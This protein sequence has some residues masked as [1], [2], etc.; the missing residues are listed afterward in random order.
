MKILKTRKKMVVSG[1]ALTVALFAGG[2]AFAYF[3]AG[4]AGSGSAP[5]G[6]ASA[7]NITQD[8]SGSAAY[9]SLVSPTPPDTWSQSYGGTGIT[10]FGDAITLAGGT[11]PLNSV[12]VAL[13]SQACGNGEGGTDLCDDPRGNVPASMTLNVYGRKSRRYSDRYGYFKHSRFPYR[14]PPAS[15]GAGRNLNGPGYQNDGSQWYD[16]NHGSATHGTSY[17]RG[18]NFASQNVTLRKL[19]LM[20]LP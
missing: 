6:T 16:S 12:V 13:D 4:G 11:A 18:I 19:M 15:C 7:V 2:A 5:I 14:P 3:S 1:L 10:Q 17:R 9:D 20:A 8:P